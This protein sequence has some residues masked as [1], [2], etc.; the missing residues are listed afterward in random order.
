MV[1]FGLF[2]TT[3]EEQ[4]F[5]LP[6]V[7]YFK[8]YSKKIC[9]TNCSSVQ[10]QVAQLGKGPAQLFL[11]RIE[12]NRTEYSEKRKKQAYQK[13]NDIFNAYLRNFQLSV[14]QVFHQSRTKLHNLVMAQHSC[15]CTKSSKVI[16]RMLEAE[17]SEK[18]KKHAYWKFN[19]ILNTYSR[20][21]QFIIT[22]PSCTTW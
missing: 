3:T 8:K 12:Q 9:F 14:S 22:E 7:N 5:E 2:L 20:D 18:R 4:K 6:L 11:H 16:V 10:S 21:L 1:V 15:F 17:F 19:V 13:F